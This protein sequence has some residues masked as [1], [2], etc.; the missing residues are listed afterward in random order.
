[1]RSACACFLWQRRRLALPVLDDRDR[2]L[3]IG[4]A[5][6]LGAALGAKFG[7]WIEDPRN[8]FADFPTGAICSKARR[9]SARCSADLP[10]S[11]L[12]KRAIGA[13]GSSGDAF[14][15]PLI[16][17]IAIGR[18]GCFCLASTI[19][20]TAIRPACL[21]RSISATR[22]APSDP[23][24]RDRLSGRT[25]HAV[26]LA[27]ALHSISR[28]TAFAP[29]WSRT[30]PFALAIDF[31]KPMPQDLFRALSGIQLL[32]LGGLLYYHRD[33]LRIAGRWRG[34]EVKAVPVLR[35]RRVGVHDVPAPRRS[36]D[37][38]QGR[39]RIPRKVVPEHGRE[40]VL[41]ADD[42]AYYR[43]SRESSSSR[44]AAAALQHRT[45]LGLP[46]R[47]RLC[48]NTCSTAA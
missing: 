10:A 25:G 14:A 31:I 3:W 48:P 18:I 29:S 35:Q 5:A 37:P 42:A 7:Y 30:L 33:I 40:R 36:E 13:Q 4:V 32:C 6:I 43:K 11:K 12:V 34:G 26:A 20:P 46:V 22:A 17:G 15:L 24:L 19:T 23:A 45:A 39:T 8:A 47:L 44:R 41:I 1:M 27:P 9:S 21:G 16:V 28:A 38:D 2:S